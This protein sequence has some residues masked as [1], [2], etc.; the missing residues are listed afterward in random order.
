MTAALKNKFNSTWHT[1]HFC[2]WLLW[3]Y[4]TW[5]LC[6]ISIVCWVSG[7]RGVT[8]KG[9][10]GRSVSS[11]LFSIQMWFL[12]EWNW[13][14]K[15]TETSHLEDGHY[16]DY[17]WRLRLRRRDLVVPRIKLEHLLLLA[18][19]VVEEKL[20][21]SSQKNWND[22]EDLNKILAKPKIRQNTKYYMYL[23]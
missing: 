18:V 19:G 21:N 15:Y 3:L 17:T 20:Q 5:K 9:Q 11:L 13:K 1:S 6:S 2:G 8:Q 22:L 7:Q 4:E 12:H 16:A 10:I 14:F 23:H